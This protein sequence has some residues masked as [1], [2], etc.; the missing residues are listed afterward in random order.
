MRPW[1]PSTVR[2]MA[3]AGRW[4]TQKAADIV[5]RSVLVAFQRQHIVSA[6]FDDLGCE[7]TLAVERINRDDAVL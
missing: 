2:W 5:V 4:I 3:R 1:S 6:L 7:Q